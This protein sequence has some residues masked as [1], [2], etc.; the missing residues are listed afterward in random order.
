MIRRFTI[1]GHGQG[2]FSVCEDTLYSPETARNLAYDLRAD[3]FYSEAGWYA[4]RA[5]EGTQFIRE[6]SV[7]TR[8]WEYE[9]P[10]KVLRKVTREQ[11]HALD[12]GQTITVYACIY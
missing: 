9:L 1:K 6:T 7:G 12:K 2:Y 3:G 11:R 5:R 8:F 10:R 4:A